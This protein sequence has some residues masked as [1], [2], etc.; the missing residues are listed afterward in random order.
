LP[1]VLGVAA[2]AEA[3]PLL[4]AD[5]AELRGQHDLVPASGDGAADQPLVGEWPVRV[6][7]VQEVTPRSSARWMVAI[8]SPSSLRP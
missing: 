2:D 6:G 1:H 3:L 4:V 7:G 5:V 8:A